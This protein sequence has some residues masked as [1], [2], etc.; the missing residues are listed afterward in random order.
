M[1]IVT[2]SKSHG[3]K[4]LAGLVDQPPLSGETRPCVP[5]LGSQAACVCIDHSGAAVW[6]YSSSVVVNLLKHVL[7]T[8]I[9]FSST[10]PQINLAMQVNRWHG[11][12]ELTFWLPLSDIRSFTSPLSLGFISECGFLWAVMRQHPDLLILS[13]VVYTAF[14]YSE[15]ATQQ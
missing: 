4:M 2:R 9:N 12:N 7:N 14:K 3:H 6:C 8:G 13:A 5:A 10:W 1:I 15:I 11:N